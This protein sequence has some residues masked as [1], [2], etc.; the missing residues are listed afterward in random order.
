MKGVTMETKQIKR[1]ATVPQIELQET[2]PV[3]KKGKKKWKKAVAV[4][5]VWFTSIIIGSWVLSNILALLA[6]PGDLVNLSKFVPLSVYLLI[7]TYGIR[8][9]V[10][11][12]RQ[13]K[14][15]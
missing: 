14:E 8:L 6:L 2:Q 7:L 10:W 3:S 13:M 15:E 1:L 5:W 11:S 12:I 4:E 9:T